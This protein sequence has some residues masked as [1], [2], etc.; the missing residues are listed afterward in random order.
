MNK[1]EYVDF[2]STFG[3]ID[4]DSKKNGESKKIRLGRETQKML[5]WLEER[6]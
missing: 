3:T 2:V 4:T 6:A 5:Q 1:N